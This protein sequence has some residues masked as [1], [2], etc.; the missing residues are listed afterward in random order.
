MNLTKRG[1]LK[2]TPEIK[3]K[4]QC[5]Y[6]MVI[7]PLKIKKIKIFCLPHNQNRFII[8]MFLS[9]LY[10]VYYLCTQSKTYSQCAKKIVQIHEI[11]DFQ[12]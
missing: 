7:S 11:I 9:H 12:N 8:C 4:F 10:L 6:K 3:P 1:A 5:S 2:Q